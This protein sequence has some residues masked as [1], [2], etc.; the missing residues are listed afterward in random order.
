MNQKFYEI[1]Q[2]KKLSE[3]N[4]RQPQKIQK[5]GDVNFPRDSNKISE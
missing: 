5:F 3:Y 2:G 1:N 4:Y